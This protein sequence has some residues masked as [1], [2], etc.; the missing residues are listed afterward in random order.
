MK[1][2]LLGCVALLVVGSPLHAQETFTNPAVTHI[3]QSYGVTKAEAQMR[4]DLQ[5]EIM[6]LS[7]KLNA[8]GDEAYGDMYIQHEPVFKIV[9]LFADNA[10]RKAFLDSLDPKLR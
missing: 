2:R 5:A 3:M 10:D 8:S 6:A 7:E 1:N 9:I 4:V